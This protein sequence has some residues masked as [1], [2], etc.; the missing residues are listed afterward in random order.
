MVNVIC[1]KCP[2]CGAPVENDVK[3]CE[4]CNSPIIITSFADSFQLPDINKYTSAYKGALTSAPDDPN[5]NAAI[6][7][8][9]MRLKMYSQART[10]FQKAIDGGLINAD[11]F[12][13]TAVC[14][15]DGKKAF[16]AKRPTID[17]IQELI[18]AA[19][20]IEDKGI[21]AYFHAYIKFDYFKRKSL[22]TSPNYVELLRKAQ[23][24]GVSEHDIGILFDLLRVERP[25]E[26]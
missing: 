5:L 11:T 12:F 14:L 23:R 20:A 3:R 25:S 8:C 13:Y 21:Y 6:G 10:C 16:L 17:K 1:P 4:Y 18:E 9:Y 26:L 22:I 7:F 2:N 15:L 24:L 19:R